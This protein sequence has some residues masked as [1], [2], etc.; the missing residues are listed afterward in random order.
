MLLCAPG[1]HAALAPAS[2]IDGPSPSILSV[3][4]A[5]MAA[6]GSGGILY[7]KLLGGQPHLFVSRFAGGTWQPPIQVDAGQ[8]FGASFPTIAAGNGGRLL[9]VWAEPWAVI[10]Q[11]THYQLMSAELLPGA[12]QFAAALQVD[13]RDIGDG[14]AAF[15]ALA[16]APNGQ[17]YV[18]YRVVTNTLIGSTIIPLRPG[19]ELV[20]VRVARY[21]GPGLAWSSLGTINTHPQLTMR[22]PS[23]SNAP[24]IGVDLAGNAVVVWQEPEATGVAR[25][26]AMRIFGNRLGNPMEA[27]QSSAGGHPITTE[28]DAPA[29]AV[30]A[31]GEAR[32][33]YRLAGGSGSP[34]GSARVLVSALPAEVDPAGAKL[35]GA[36]VLGAASTPG[37]PSVAIDPRGAFRVA[38][39][40]E[41]SADLVSGND[42]DPL[43]SPEVLG[44]ANSSSQVLTTVNPA[45]GG[46][47]VWP[48]AAGNRPVIQ[49]REDFP[50]GAWQSALLSAPIS[51]PMGAPT[52]GASGGGDA[53]IAFAQGPADQQQV[54]ASVAKAPPGQFLATVPVGWVRGTAAT[55]SWE[56][57]SE[58]FGATTY[59]VLLDGHTRMRGLSRLAAHLDPRALGDG[60][61]HVQVLATDSLGQQTMTAVADLKIDA[62]P[63]EASVRTLRGRLVR[64]RVS[65]RASG[66]LAKDT[67]IS[68]GDGARASHRLM[69]KHVYAQ[70]GSYTIA[71]RSRDRVGHILNVHLRVQVR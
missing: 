11:S 28:A 6:D 40:G 31:L 18:V 12:S 60:V 15:P 30:G 59:A 22:H 20:D 4:A 36:A 13:P 62:N 3:D 44:A 32:I 10:N 63:P 34:Y 65:D 8:P 9:V 51:G 5:A 35:K 49:A 47:T 24:A 43:G 38:Y 37:P 70:S 68:F 16:M 2:L 46:L 26:R 39:A 7:R 23:A 21:N 54:M 42:F 67:T 48:T 27:S 33:A 71:V 57:P 14:T 29:V 58:A 17:A 66:A 19:D 69:A 50:D 55:V 41:A 53:L 1:A 64:V 52:L 61:H 25:I 56:A 45:G